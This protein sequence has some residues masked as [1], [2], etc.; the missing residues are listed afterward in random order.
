MLYLIAFGAGVFA[1]F[2]AFSAVMATYEMRLT[3]AGHPNAHDALWEWVKSFPEL[4]MLLKLASFACGLLSVLAV[5]L[6]YN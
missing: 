1:P 6:I 3:N 2:L 4:R 5:W